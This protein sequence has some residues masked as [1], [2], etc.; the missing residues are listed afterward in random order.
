[1]DIEARIQDLV[2]RYAALIRAVIQANLHAGDALDPQD[3]EQEIRI[4]L[5]RGIRQGKKIANWPSYIKRVAYTA[6]IDELRRLRKQAPYRGSADWSRMLLTMERR[7]D[8]TEAENPESRY[9]RAE[10]DRR[11]ASLVGS[12]SPDRRRILRL[13]AGGLG[14]EEI[15]GFL[16]W[17]KVRV[18]H[19]LYRGLD[20]LKRLTGER[21]EEPTES[22]GPSL[23]MQPVRK[24]R[25]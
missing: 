10:R 20:D 14:V 24:E 3:I 6:T 21:D 17:D 15:C 23:S 18:R 5:W 22:A 2:A 16:G 11:I 9:D 13:Y 8:G 1:M 7:R 19:L 4:R 25:G 12:L